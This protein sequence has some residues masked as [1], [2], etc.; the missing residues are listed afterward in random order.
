[1]SKRNSDRVK[2]NF[3]W[4]QPNTGDLAKKANA[5][6][7]GSIKTITDRLQRLY[8]VAGDAQVHKSVHQSTHMYEIRI[9]HKGHGKQ[10]KTEWAN[11]LWCIATLNNL[12]LQFHHVWNAKIEIDY[13]ANRMPW[14]FYTKDN[15][16]LRPGSKT[17]Q[18]NDF[19]KSVNV[20]NPLVDQMQLFNVR[21]PPIEADEFLIVGE[22]RAARKV[23][24]SFNRVHSGETYLS[25]P[26]PYSN[27]WGYVGDDVVMV[28]YRHGDS[29]WL[30]LP[31]MGYKLE[32]S[33][34]VT[35]ML[36]GVMEASAEQLKYGTTS[37]SM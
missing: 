37:I 10:R 2:I 4:T 15:V 18:V 11:V 1:M 19:G 13:G 21:V 24:R 27:K 9:K 35:G 6:I 26:T 30:P 29:G 17:Y 36:T 33:P 20:L 8:Y 5:S 28:F 3:Q 14:V 34:F 25:L 16:F 12:I 23:Y 32:S 31:G 22:P 7:H